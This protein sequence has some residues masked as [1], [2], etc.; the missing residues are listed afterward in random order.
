MCS[1]NI[2]IFLGINVVF[3][4]DSNLFRQFQLQKR[5]RKLPRDGVSRDA[6][7]LQGE[8]GRVINNSWQDNK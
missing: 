2:W 3:F 8:S 5:E 1:H 6:M 7:T 4:D